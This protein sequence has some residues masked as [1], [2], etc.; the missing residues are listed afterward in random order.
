MSFR[1]RTTRVLKPER[2]QNRGRTLATGVATALL[3]ASLAGCTTSQNSAPAAQVALP[4]VPMGPA[5][6]VTSAD[7]VGEWG[8]ASYRNE[9]DRARTEAEAKVACGNPYR[10]A[11]GTSGGV[12]MHLADQTETSEVFIK[13]GPGGQAFIG[14]QGPP[15]VAQDRLVL[16]Y[17]NG[18]VLITEWLDA[19]VRERYGTM[20][21]VRCGVA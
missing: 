17:E 13:P 7:L 10:I 11:A 18:S 21:Y 20:I 12:M 16:A 8:L 5:V 14:P 3:L 9:A 15:A 2:R 1:A 19:G 4:A 6:T